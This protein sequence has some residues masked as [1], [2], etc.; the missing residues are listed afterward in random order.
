MFLAVCLSFVSDDSCLR[1]M[2]WARC[3]SF[4]I[5]LTG[6]IVGRVDSASSGL[7]VGLYAGRLGLSGAKSGTLIPLFFY[8]VQY[9]R[10]YPHER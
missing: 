3:R 8:Q 5:S 10:S 1:D 6:L 4:S 9:S 7:L 2:K